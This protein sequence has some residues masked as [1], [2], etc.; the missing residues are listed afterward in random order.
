MSVRW[1]H[2][3]PSKNVSEKTS[4]RVLSGAHPGSSLFLL[5]SRV[6][7]MGS[8]SR[9]QRVTKSRDDSMM[10][11]YSRKEMEGGRLISALLYRVPWRTGRQT[12]PFTIHLR[13]AAC[14]Q[15]RP[16]TISAFTHDVVHHDAPP[17]I[18]L[19]RTADDYSDR[20]GS[21]LIF[22]VLFSLRRVRRS[23]WSRLFE[24]YDQKK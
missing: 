15:Y 22:L 10:A 19:Q 23:S 9:Y 4:K 5:S 18:E 8:I 21:I 1:K 16:L 12:Q 24:K 13:C 11:K 3:I 17:T 6:L 20:E 14:Q 2:Y 7:P